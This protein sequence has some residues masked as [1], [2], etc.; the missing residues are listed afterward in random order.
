MPVVCSTLGG[1]DGLS[2]SA[3]AIS[4]RDVCH[5][6]TEFLNGFDWDC[7]L[8]PEGLAEGEVR[9]VDAIHGDV[10][11]IG[12]S[13]RYRAIAAAAGIAGAVGASLFALRVNHAG[14]QTQQSGGVITKFDGQGTDSAQI[15]IVADGAVGGVQRDR[16]F[17]SDLDSLI[18]AANLELNIL[19][20]GGGDGEI[21]IGD[22]IGL[23]SVFGDG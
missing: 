11:L 8:G 4:R 14:L 3:T 20:A 21:E 1:D 19:R 23:K 16:A 10:I 6:R 13:A 9:G 2:S 17:R 12:A 5:L 22:A 18:H 15:E 7:G